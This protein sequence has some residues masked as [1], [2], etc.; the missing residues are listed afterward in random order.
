MRS[1]QVL[2]AL[3]ASFWL[4]G[5]AYCDTHVKMPMRD[6][7]RL[8]A[9]VFHPRA[10]GR[11]PTILIRT[12][13]NKG[14][15]NP[16]E[17]FIRRGYNVVIQDVRGRYH[18]GG[19]FDPLNQEGRD[20][21]DTIEWIAKQPWSDGQVG[22]LGGSYVGIAQWKA[23]LA[24]NPHLKAI[25]PV[26]SGYDDYLDRFYSTGG[27]FKLAHRLEW[28]SENLRAPG[29][30]KP[31]FQKFIFH[32][33][34]R[35]SD[36][37]ATGQTNEMYQA[38]LDH[39]VYD[40]WWK[41]LS[42]R[43]AIAKLRVPVFSVGG[44]YDNFGESD[45]E[46]FAALAKRGAAVR[47]LIGPWPHNMSMKFAGVDYGPG[48]VAPIRE[49]QHEWF[50]YWM[51]TPAK[52]RKPLGP[53][54][55][56]FVMGAN[57]WRDESQWPPAGT[58]EISYYLSSDGNANSSEGEG[59][60]RRSPGVDEPADRYTYDPRNPVPT[61]GGAICCNP[62]VFPWGPLD[63]RAVERRSDVLV[64][65]TEPLKRDLEVLGPLR[66]VLYVSTSA[67]DTDFTAKLVDVFPDG[68][69]RNLS[70]GILRMR[71][72]NGID[73]VASAAHPSEIYPIT[74]DTGVTANV[75]LKGHSVRLEIS[76]SNFPRFDRNPN[77][78]RPIAGETALRTAN[79]TVYHGR[80]YPS[81]ILLPVSR[82]FSNPQ[83]SLK[84]RIVSNAR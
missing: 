25:F 58:R 3:A 14:V 20:G 54:L 21:Y 71:Y 44:W 67:P 32:L 35:T 31:D 80:Q 64:Y 74:I 15:A 4:P 81:R 48:A 38:V 55:R 40:E 52:A 17:S 10:A 72:R 63:Q 29:F 62:K 69:A 47:T 23:A 28:M 37:A 1:I 8:C 53:P 61:A 83:M 82:A 50:D 84:S 78:G 70:D 13:Y 79:Q 41:R 11:V 18:S 30:E 75:F 65:T 36:A 45:L 22:M 12:P 60:L 33:P 7:V 46:A 59:R 56:L 26:V 49:L 68:R 24:N 51:K 5:A 9:L 73:R 43:E 76:S 16:Y 34:L 6:G 77:T 39:P 66:V 57:R 2:L 42:V 27:A 19:E